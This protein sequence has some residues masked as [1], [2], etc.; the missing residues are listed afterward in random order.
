MAEVGGGRQLL[1]SRDMSKDRN[2]AISAARWKAVVR[3]FGVK[4]QEAWRNVLEKLMVTA[5]VSSSWDTDCE[6]CHLWRMRIMEVWVVGKRHRKGCVSVS[7][8]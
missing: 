1:N 8:R 7:V 2:P 6:V 3:S 4:E 5:F